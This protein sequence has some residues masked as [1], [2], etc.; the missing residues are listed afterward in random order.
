MLMEKFHY[1][2]IKYFLE[3]CSSFQLLGE[4]PDEEIR[5]QLHELFGQYKLS[6]GD[7]INGSPVYEHVQVDGFLYKCTNKTCSHVS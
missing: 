3:C 5:I 1:S 7:I 2:F 6:P 4:V